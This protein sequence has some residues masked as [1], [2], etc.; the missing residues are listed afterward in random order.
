[1]TLGKSIRLSPPT[2]FNLQSVIHSH[3]WYRLP[4]FS[5]DEERGALSRV[6]ALSDGAIVRYTVWEEDGA[7]L[8]QVGEGRSA[9]QL[10]EIQRNLARTLNWEL[11]L[12]QF[13]EYLETFPEYAWVA[14]R[15]LGRKLKCSTVWEDAVKT[16]LTTNTTWAMTIQMVTRVAELGPR[17]PIDEGEGT[18]VAFPTPQQLYEM[19]EA[20]LSEAV[21][22]GYRNAYLYEL[23]ARIAN[24]ELDLEAWFADDVDDADQNADQNTDRT[25]YKRL[26]SLKGFG[27]Y[28]VSS[29]MRIYGR[30]GFLSIDTVARAAYRALQPAAELDAKALDAA[31]REHY[32]PHSRWQ[33]L[34]QWLDVM[35]AFEEGMVG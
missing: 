9:N 3:G 29:L 23:A 33:A 7:L 30:F 1:M 13:Y 21:R 15:A 22:A 16:L 4:P 18:F 12:A 31:I 11:D 26:R 5:L 2:P 25:L 17:Q 6:D 27:D 14:P 28:A 35:R 8:L 34:M 19:G 24:G 10:A 20:A 32:A